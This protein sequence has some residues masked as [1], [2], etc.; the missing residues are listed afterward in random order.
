[1]NP[2]KIL[3]FF[4]L[5]CAFAAPA[6]AQLGDRITPHFGLMQEVVILREVSN[7]P[8][9]PTSEA[10]AIFTMGNF[11]GYGHFA[12]KNDVV[13][14]GVDAS[15]QIGLQLTFDGRVSFSGMTPVYL[16]GRIG[17]GATPYNSQAAGFALGIGAN[18]LYLN[19]ANPGSTRINSFAFAPS[20]V[21]QLKVNAFGSPITGR[22]HTS[23]IPTRTN[24]NTRVPSGGT[25]SQPYDFSFFG[26]GL[27]MEL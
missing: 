25:N 19:L 13:S 11:G 8:G 5:A 24:L 4:V 7:L 21:A 26:F 14:V 22:I 16:M 9:V 10:R 15:A 1:M 27:M 2:H 23:L 20:A 17:A 12:H 6:F 3:S 18:S